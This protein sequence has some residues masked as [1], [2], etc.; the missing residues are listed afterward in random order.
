[1]VTHPNLIEYHENRVKMLRG[2]VTRWYN[3][4]RDAVDDLYEAEQDLRIARRG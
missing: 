3:E 1:M 2:Q 4:H